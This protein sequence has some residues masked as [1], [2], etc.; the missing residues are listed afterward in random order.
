MRKV[1]NIALMLGT[2][3]ALTLPAVSVGQE[4]WWGTPSGEVQDYRDSL[5]HNIPVWTTQDAKQFPHCKAGDPATAGLVNYV[6]VKQDA[7]RAFM[8]FGEAWE[9]GHDDNRAND[10][11][12]IGIC[13]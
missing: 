3:L 12:I 7:S 11:W 13:Q 8:T 2:V 5:P 1:M 6:V 9:R 10:V 4:D